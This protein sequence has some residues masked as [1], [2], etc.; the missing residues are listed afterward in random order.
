MKYC[1]NCGAAVALVLPPGDDRPRYVCPACGTVHYQN[2]RMVVG[3]IPEWEDKILFCRRRIEPRAGKWTVPAGFLE[4]GETVAAGA[5]RETLEEARARV[6]RLVPFALFN[7]TFVNQVYFMFRGPLADGR[8]A[9]GDESLEA[10]LFTE[11]QVPWDEIAFPVIR[12][13]LRLYFADR[14]RGNFRFHMGDIRKE[15]FT[16]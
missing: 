11:A 4:N 16:Q 15:P 3:C 8:F 2:P 1:S 13:S 5:A 7:L 12:E 9:A 10:E 14:A 6:V